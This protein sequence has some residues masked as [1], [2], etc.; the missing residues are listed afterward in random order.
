MRFSRTKTALSGLLLAIPLTISSN[1]FVDAKN[2]RPPQGAD[3][4]APASATSSSTS[5]VKNFLTWPVRALSRDDDEEI[6]ASAYPL[7]STRAG[8]G[9][10]DKNNVLFSFTLY[11]SAL[12]RH[13]RMRANRGLESTQVIDTAIDFSAAAD[14]DS[15][16]VTFAAADSEKTN[17]ETGEEVSDAHADDHGDGHVV[18][19]SNEATDAHGETSH[20]D[21]AHL[22]AHSMV[23]HVTYE[24]ICEY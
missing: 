1:H 17:E 11:G 22:D 16:L 9:S 13:Q 21:D 7:W 19:A 10:N 8:N 15:T 23:V 18:S 4:H 20:E 12:E 6:R 14:S 3:H 2:L 5:I 24:D